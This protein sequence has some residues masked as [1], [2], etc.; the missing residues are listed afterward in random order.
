MKSARIVAAA[1]ALSLAGCTPAEEGEEGVPGGAE[2]SP[3]VID[4]PAPAPAPTIAAAP[5]PPCDAPAPAV[6]AGPLVVSVENVTLLFDGQPNDRG[7]RA[8]TGTASLVLKTRSAQPIQVA[9]LKKSITLTY[10][11]GTAM[12]LNDGKR[13]DYSGLS[14]CGFDGVSCLNNQDTPFSTVSPGDSPL[15]VNFRFRKYVDA[16]EAATLAQANAA[17]LALSLWVI[18]TDPKGEQRTVS[19]GNVPVKNGTIQ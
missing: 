9:M 7:S 12:T 15:R 3:A 8:L 17:D 19:V 5:P 14:F 13:S 4:T 18:E 1:L 11:N 10:N 6:C 16:P 2:T